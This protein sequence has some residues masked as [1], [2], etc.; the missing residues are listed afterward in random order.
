MQKVE[1][2]SEQLSLSF[3]SQ[4]YGSD[5]QKKA[6]CDIFVNAANC[7]H[8]QKVSVACSE[9]MIKPQRCRHL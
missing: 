8:P 4:S 9:V 6:M 3:K 2:H 7:C 5:I 1:K